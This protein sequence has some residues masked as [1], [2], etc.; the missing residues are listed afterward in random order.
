LKITSKISS[1]KTY[2]FLV[3]FLQISIIPK[4]E[5]V[6]AFFNFF[7]FFKK[8]VDFFDFLLYANIEVI[9]M[10]NLG[11]GLKKIRLSKKL[12]LKDVAENLGISKQAL[13]NIETGTTKKIKREYLEA[14]YELYEINEE[15][16][17]NALG[18]AYSTLES[19]LSFEND[20]ITNIKDIS[21]IA[22]LTTSLKTI[23]NLKK[24]N[25]YEEQV[26]F[27]ATLKAYYEIMRN[28]DFKGKGG[29]DK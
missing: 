23:L 13:I 3:L 1:L 16:I 8:T 6:N 25:D 12:K 28:I 2:T 10:E 29:K 15:D 26:V 20:I 18:G 5:K 11:F 4:I 14:F 7:T 27:N 21:K 22:E 17:M 9:N 24:L 19:R